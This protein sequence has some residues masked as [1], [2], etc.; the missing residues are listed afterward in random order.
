MG[1]RASYEPGTFSWVDLGTTDPDAAKAFYAGLFGWECED[2]PVGDS[3]TYTICRLDG[4]DVCAIAGQNQQER[5]QDVPPHWNSYITVDD[6]DARAP[7]IAELNGNLIMPP[8]DVAQAGRMALGSDPTGAVFA[9]W[10]PRD[11]IGAALVNAPG[12]LTWNELVTADFD[13]VRR[14]YAD[15]FGWAYQDVEGSP[16]PYAI[17]RNGDR[18]NGSIRAQGNAEK[19]MPSYWAP[20]FA[21]ASCDESCAKAVELGG[22]VVVVTAR[23]PA[24]AFAGLTDPPGAFF[25]IFEGEFDD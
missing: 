19:G 5:D 21:V 11:H 3:G 4:K 25:A 1:E 20:Y 24:G 16:I 17:I 22:R 8:F 14:F 7:R 13:A 15:L 12:A 6:V 2:M 18:S 10:E 9:L 23:V